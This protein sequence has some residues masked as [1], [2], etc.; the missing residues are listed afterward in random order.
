[1]SDVPYD[2]TI[3]EGDSI[4]PKFEDSNASAKQV[5]HQLASVKAGEAIL[6]G[7]KQFTRPRNAILVM[8]SVASKGD[9][10]SRSFL[11]LIS[12][13]FSI[14]V[15]V[16]GTATFA[17]AQ[18]IALPVATL[19][20]TLI[21]AAALVARAITGW[22]VAGVNKAEPLIHVIVNTTQEAQ[23]L[24]GRILSIDDY[25]GRNTE[26][27]K[28]RK[29]QVELGGH[30]FVEQRRVGARSRWYLRIL[31]VLAE[32]FDLRKVNQ[33]GP[34]LRAVHAKTGTSEIELGLLREQTFGQH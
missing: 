3:R 28:S 2:V 9:N 32:P 26:E 24:I 20:L 25:D 27:N 5:L 6:H 10:R 11:R 34:D 33:S 22:I 19:A 13:C 17:S 31:G 12:K 15:F 16:F 18:L 29:V 21:L 7:S 8:I 4:L 30:V 23:S 14:G 1:M